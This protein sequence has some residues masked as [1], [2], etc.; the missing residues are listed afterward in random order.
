MTQ[1]FS[2]V[3]VNALARTGVISRLGAVGY[4]V[5]KRT[6]FLAS[7]KR[8]FSVPHWLGLSI[9]ILMAW[10]LASSREREQ[11]G[12]CPTFIA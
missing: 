9:V 4:T 6:R 2:R 8:E 7:Y 3:A 10:K 5:D 11:T 12:H 1:S